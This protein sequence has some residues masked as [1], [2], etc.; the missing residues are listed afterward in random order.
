M[1]TYLIIFSLGIAYLS[2]GQT[3]DKRGIYPF[4]EIENINMGW[5]NPVVAK[6]P[7]KAFSQYGRTYTAAQTDAAQKI[8]LWTQQTF[9]QPGLLGDIQ[10]ALFAPEPSRPSNSSAY[11]FNEAEK[12]NRN[13]L[14]NSYGATVKF[15]QCIS[16]TA[17]KKFWP[18][19][20]NHCY[21][22]LHIMANDIQ[23][24]T[25]QLV[26]LSSPE[27]YYFYMP[28]YDENL[29]GRFAEDQYRKALNY[30]QFNNNPNLK[31]YEHY[32][33]PAATVHI[34]RS[35]YTV[36]MTRDNAPLPF[37]QVTMGEF[38]NRLEAQFPTLHKIAINDK[39]TQRMPSVLEDAKR[40]IQILKKRYSKQL[41]DFVYSATLDQIDLLALSQIE[42]GKEIT[43]IKTSSLT[44]NKNGWSE[45][46]FPLLRMKKGIKELL[47]TGSPQWIVFRMEF[48][49]NNGYGGAVQMIDN[50]ISRFNYDYVYRYFFGKNKP[51]ELYK[52]LGNAIANEK[53]GAAPEPS[54]V[55]KKKAADASILFFEDFSGTAR[56]A[57]PENWNTER[58]AITGSLPLVTTLENTEG[59]WLVLRRTASPKKLPQN[60]SGDFELSYD[61]A[62]KK[63][64]VP[65]GTP[66]IDMKLKFSEGNSERQITLNVSPGDMNR[67]E[68]A[69]WIMIEALTGCKVSSDYSLPDFTGSKPV[70]KATISLQKKGRSIV[71]LCNNTKV[72]ECADAFTQPFALKH[73]SFYVNEKNQFHLS[74]IQI[75]KI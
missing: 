20:G 31:N 42:D 19:P 37:E 8:A 32:I 49:M 3:P 55:A 59:N 35:Y 74:N 53:S 62:V 24:I 17:N 25:T 54:A 36:I 61:L 75:R 66:G 45:T 56:E 12:N 73:L 21:M 7:A 51:T 60:I 44:D 34:T 26:A 72:Y 52:P 6:E 28:K 4:E 14:P 64:D 41:N 50:F 5:I 43:W 1:K 70:N 29:K 27:E 40:G 68:A 46:G 13:S 10:I 2:K 11:N 47:A 16:K 9:Q 18:T 69:G 63:G 33:I 58:S 15:H 22:S 38:L 30:R 67:T 48:P 71:I 23:N 39:L 65:W 57:T